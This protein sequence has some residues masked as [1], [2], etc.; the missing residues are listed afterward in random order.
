MV[1]SLQQ[2][3]RRKDVSAPRLRSRR[4]R[5]APKLG[6]SAS[7][8]SREGI[9]NQHRRRDDSLS[10][11]SKGSSLSGTELD[12]LVDSKDD[13]T[14]S[15]AP[16]ATLAATSSSKGD[17]EQENTSVSCGSGTFY[18]EPKTNNG[19][20]PCTTTTGGCSLVYTFDST[21][22]GARGI[23]TDDVEYSC[24]LG[25][26][27]PQRFSASYSGANETIVLCAIGGLRDG[28]EHKLAVTMLSGT[29]T[30]EY[31]YD[32]T[33][34]RSDGVHFDS[35]AEA[36]DGTP[37]SAD[38]QKTAE[39]PETTT[40]SD[41]TTASSA[42]STELS[43][44]ATSSAIASMPA[45]SSD[46]GVKLVVG[47]VGGAVVLLLV[48]WIGYAVWRHSKGKGKAQGGGGGD[49]GSIKI[50]CECAKVCLAPGS[51]LTACLL[52]W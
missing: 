27:S 24:A 22:S 33:D 29:L 39:E 52:R 26:A 37:T 8:A 12:D 43:S 44:A 15:E 40:S 47:L 25:D 5:L 38:P 42:S 23:I 3:P 11:D 35:E 13:T 51:V 30:V 10:S 1:S 17:C 14:S 19:W 20:L 2:A 41:D 18:Q 16:T 48:V 49:G 36:L 46:S 7:T 45:S 50:F 6:T 34:V 9:A 21:G 32:Q 4:S 31:F 28:D